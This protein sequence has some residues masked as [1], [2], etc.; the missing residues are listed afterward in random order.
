M[1]M[2]IKAVLLVPTLSFAADEIRDRKPDILIGC[3]E[4]SRESL[5]MYRRGFEFPNWYL[6]LETDRFSSARKFFPGMPDGIRLMV[7]RFGDATKCT[8]GDNSEG[9]PSV[10]CDLNDEFMRAITDFMDDRSGYIQYSIPFPNSL[11][12]AITDE[13]HKIKVTF[14]NG[15]K[16]LVLKTFDKSKCL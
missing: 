6:E 11:K 16:S 14:F 10:A 12:F 7:L 8:Y 1:K 3:T 13:S 15:K 2:V 9:H 4:S 5:Q